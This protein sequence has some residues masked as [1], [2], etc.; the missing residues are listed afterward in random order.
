MKDQKSFLEPNQL[1]YE[2]PPPPVRSRATPAKDTYPQVYEIHDQREEEGDG[3]D[4]D[5]NVNNKSTEEKSVIKAEETSSSSSSSSSSNC[6][7][8]AENVLE[9]GDDGI[10]AAADDS[11]CLSS[12]SAG[13]NRT[14]NA[15]D[16]VS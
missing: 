8:P 14:T 1:D 6:P 4:E 16:T 5:K 11:D 15:S 3:Q 10:A 7:K 9:A 13:T 2:M 12:V